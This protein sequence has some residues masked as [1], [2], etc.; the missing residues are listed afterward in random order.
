MSATTASAS[1]TRPRPMSQRGDSGR[2]TRSRTATSA[3]SAPTPYIQRQ[4][5]SKPGPACAND[6]PFG[7]GAASVVRMSPSQMPSSA[8]R[9]DMTKMSEVN[10][11]RDRRGATSPMNVLT[12]ARSAPIPCR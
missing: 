4:P 8:P 11:A 6:R 1:S 9:A 10:V 2:R 5:F 7:H 12:I 3:S